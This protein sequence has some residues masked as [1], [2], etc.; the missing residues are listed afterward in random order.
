[1]AEPTPLP[2]S[3]PQEEAVNRPLLVLTSAG[4]AFPARVGVAASSVA[5]AAEAPEPTRTLP[6]RCWSR[7]F[8][9][10]RRGA[11]RT[12]PCPRPKSPPRTRPP[13]PPA[14]RRGAH[15]PQSRPRPVCTPNGL[16]VSSGSSSGTDAEGE[17]GDSDRRPRIVTLCY[18]RIHTLPS[19][20]S[21]DA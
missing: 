9:A 11:L 19:P 20:I 14:A 15:A 4:F 10:C 16:R 3:L 8:N 18:T 5:D 12:S 13:A 2:S 21:F 17:G 6:R 7:R 1:M